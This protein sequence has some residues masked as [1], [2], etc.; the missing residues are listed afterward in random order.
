MDMKESEKSIFSSVGLTQ[1]KISTPKVMLKRHLFFFCDNG[2]KSVKFYT[3]IT[4][5]F[6]LLKD[7]YKYNYTYK[8]GTKKYQT[9]RKQILSN[10]C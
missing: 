4:F 1:G 3:T 5:Q 2:K 9:I 10:N 7:A 8:K 6:M